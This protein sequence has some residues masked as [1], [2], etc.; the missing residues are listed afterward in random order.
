MIHSSIHFNRCMF[1]ACGYVT[2]TILHLICYMIYYYISWYMQTITRQVC[3][4]RITSIYL[5]FV[6]ASISLCTVSTCQFYFCIH[7]CLWYAYSYLN[8][9][10]LTSLCYLLL[11]RLS[12][13]ILFLWSV[14]NFMSVQLTIYLQYCKYLQYRLFIYI[15]IPI[16]SCLPI[17]LFW[18][19]SSFAC[20]RRPLLGGRK[21]SPSVYSY[22]RIHTYTCLI[23]VS[24]THVL[25]VSLSINTW[26]T[27]SCF[28]IHQFC[29]TRNPCPFG[30]VH[31]NEPGGL[32]MRASRP[33]T[34]V[35]A[36]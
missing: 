9:T 3:I 36:E 2:A 21:R 20:F 25:S 19:I 13:A 30:T 6:S 27:N 11:Y 8:T 1:S 18:F 12:H 35:W 14:S 31:K 16:H 22:I 28:S 10:R 26:P 24:C 23:Y 33:L 34:G 17:H 15:Y 29:L 7:A 5:L 32:P 4:M